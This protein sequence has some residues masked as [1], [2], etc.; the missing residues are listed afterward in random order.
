MVLERKT[1]VLF[2]II[3]VVLCMFMV[4]APVFADD[5]GAYETKTGE[6]VNDLWENTIYKVIKEVG[7]TLAIATFVCSAFY[8]FVIGKSKAG[9][10]L[11]RNLMIGAAIGILIIYAG[12]VV[13]R[14]VIRAGQQLK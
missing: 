3:T 12:P 11:A 7:G 10:D 14:A 2:T 13:M 5:G 6:M 1:K 8:F 4:T 9:N